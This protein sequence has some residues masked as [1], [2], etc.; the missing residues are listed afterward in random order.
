MMTVRSAPHYWIE[1]DGGCGDRVPPHRW[2][3]VGV[4]PSPQDAEADA[5]D[6]EWQPT[7]D[8]RWLC[9]TCQLDEGGNGLA[10]ISRISA[11]A[12]LYRK[13]DGVVIRREEDDR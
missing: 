13:T 11:D 2:S 5:Y 9:P 10:E 8:G 3:V 7:D 1:C 4:W 12:D 6:R